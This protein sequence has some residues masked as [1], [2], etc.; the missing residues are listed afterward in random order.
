MNFEEG[1]QDFMEDVCDIL[2]I[3][4]PEISYD[5]SKFKTETMMAFYDRKAIHIKRFDKFNPDNF[6][7]IAHELRHVWQL[8]TNEEFYYGNYQDSSVLNIEEYNLQIAEIDA[9]AFATMIMIDLLHLQPKFDNFSD[10]IVEKIWDRI[11]EI[12]PKYS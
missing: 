6:F 5:T 2:D 1:I 9:N 4:V 10:E 11:K 8:R 12:V 7:A 3:D